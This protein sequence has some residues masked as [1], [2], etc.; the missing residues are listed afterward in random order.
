MGIEEY[1]FLGQ[2]IPEGE[3]CCSRP[4]PFGP[5]CICASLASAVM[6]AAGSLDSADVY[7]TLL[8]ARLVSCLSDEMPTNIT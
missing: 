8:V 7:Q 5:F 6:P 2:F 3:N 4:C 1:L